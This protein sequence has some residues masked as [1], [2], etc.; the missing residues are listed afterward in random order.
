MR[1]QVL[2]AQILT[3]DE[4]LA[5]CPVE[6]SEIAAGIAQATRSIDAAKQSIAA[7]ELKERS[8]ESDMQQQEA[9]MARLDEQT[10]QVTSQQAYK[11]I[12]SEMQNARNAGSG[13][14]TQALELMEA[15]DDARSQLKEAEEK[16]RGL[17]EEAPIRLRAVD[18]REAAFD[19]ERAG[20]L[21]T[22]LKE[23][24]D[25]AAGVLGQYERIRVRCRPTVL[26]LK[27]KACPMCRIAVPRQNVAKIERGEEVTTCSSC[28]RLLVS[29][30]VLDEE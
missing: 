24:A 11:A 19:S 23:C 2:D 28:Q 7:T 9:L 8:L 17:E 3:L 16:L 29:K 4:G 27:E 14:E 5:A 21:E 22:R 26:V 20:L 25:V 1:V 30:L 12:Q 13:F 15:L 18:D 6:R 10:Y